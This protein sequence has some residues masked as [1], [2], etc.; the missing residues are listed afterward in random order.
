MTRA[1]RKISRAIV[2]QLTEQAGACEL[3]GS[4]RNLDVHHIIPVACGGTDD[5]DNLIV[6]CKHCHGALTPQSALTKTG[7][8]NLKKRNEIVD[9]IVWYYEQI[10]PDCWNHEDWFD[11]ATEFFHRLCETVWPWTGR[12]YVREQ[13][14]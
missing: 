14:G 2:A 7:I 9:L 5:Q 3:C 6:V 11:L 13:G 10:D 4:K 1:K 12:E 8:E